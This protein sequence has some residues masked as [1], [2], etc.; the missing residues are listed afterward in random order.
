MLNQEEVVL[1]AWEE[2]NI[3]A[4]DAGLVVDEIADLLSKNNKCIL[5]IASQ[6]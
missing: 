3:L 2:Y 1:G 5:K 4:A 6:T